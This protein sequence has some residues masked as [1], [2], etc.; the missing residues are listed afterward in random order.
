[1]ELEELL[2]SIDIVEFISQ[3]IDLEQKGEEF[4]GLSCFNNEKTPSFS[5]RRDT[6]A[7]YDF[8]SGLGGN[9]LT[10]TRLFFKCSNKEA[11]EKLKAYAGITADNIVFTPKMSATMSCKKFLPQKRTEKESK[12]SVLPDDYM[13]RYEVD[14]E[15]LKL[16]EDEGISRESMEQFQVRYDSFSDRIVYPIRNPSGQIVNIGGRTLD[17]QW[18]EKGQRK[19]TY[20]KQ[21]G[22]LKVI[23][24]FSENLEAIRKKHEIIL[25][26]GCKSVLLA[27]TFGIQNTGAILTSH[28]NPAQV[29]LL[30]RLGCDVVFALD[31]DVDIRED[32]NIS[33]LKNYVNVFYLYDR[34]DLLNEKDSPVDQGKEVFL[35]LYRNKVRYR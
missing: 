4:W 1:M 24:G 33:K 35:E 19:Y 20:F 13:N 28:V 17:P 11:I 26:E 7:W 21:W 5:V 18:K 30:A 2:G 25:F 3:Y 31:K 15:K 12:T 10:F 6:G 8:S 29:K 34:D 16:W 23:Y 32:F 14:W 9:L 27:N 22:S